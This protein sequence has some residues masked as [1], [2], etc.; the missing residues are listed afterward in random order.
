MIEL[1]ITANNTAELHDTIREIL[2]DHFNSPVIDK[3]IIDTDRVNPI[4]TE[5]DQ[6]EEGTT[7]TIPEHMQQTGIAAPEGVDSAKHPWDARIHSTKYGK[8]GDGTWKIVRRPKRFE[9]NPLEWKVYIQDVLNE[10]S[11]K[12]HPDDQTPAQSPITATPITATPEH[13]SE[14]PADVFNQTTTIPSMATVSAPVDLSAFLL[15]MTSNADKITTDQVVA[16]CQKHGVP[17]LMVMYEP[18]FTNAVPLIFS[19]VQATINA[20]G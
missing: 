16:I 3:N 12:P 18:V 5:D 15:F 9:A 10:L 14:N 11:A 6:S 1:R 2:N 20:H 8:N 19:E 4:V 7:A 17:E 13:Q